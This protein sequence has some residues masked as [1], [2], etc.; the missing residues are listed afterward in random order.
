MTFVELNPVIRNF[1]S[2]ILRMT[3]IVIK[4]VM[5]LH[6]MLLMGLSWESI[7]L[8]LSNYT[9]NKHSGY[10]CYICTCLC[11]I[12]KTRQM[13]YCMNSAFHII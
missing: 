6:I 1:G 2:Q 11:A 7:T 5:V 10:C 4:E 3:L 9:Y 12:F 8:P 13:I